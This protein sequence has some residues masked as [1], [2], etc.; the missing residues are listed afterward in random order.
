M[1]ITTELIV[2]LFIIGVL[3]IAASASEQN[4]VQVK[5]HLNRPEEGRIF[6][7]MGYD[8]TF[9]G[10]EFVTL[11]ADRDGIAHLRSFGFQVEIIPPPR[12]F[13]DPIPFGGFKTLSQLTS[14]VDDMIIAHSGIMTDRV[15]IGQSCEGRDIWAVKISDNPDINEDEP[16]LFF[17]S[18]IH[19]NE[20]LTA[21]ALLYTMDYL[22]DNYGSDPEATDII[23]NRELWFVPVTNPDGYYYN[24]LTNPDGGGVWRK[25]RR[26]NGDGTFGVDLNRNF[27]YMWGYNDLG[28]SPITSNDYYRGTG[29]FSEPESQAIRD[30]VLSHEFVISVD[31]HAPGRSYIWP[32][33]YVDMRTPDDNVYTVVMDSMSSYNGFQLSDN[34]TANGVQMDW[35]YGEQSA[36]PQIL[37]M[38]PEVGDGNLW[39]DPLLIEQQ[40]AEHLGPNLFLCRFADSIYYLAPPRIPSIHVPAGP[41]GPDY[42]VSWTHDDTINTAVAFE[43]L[44]YENPA[45]IPDSGNNLDDWTVNWFHITDVDYHSPPTSFRTWV[46]DGNDLQTTEP[47]CI[48]EAET[49]SFWI[50]YELARGYDYV[51]VTVSTDGFSYTAIPGNI[52]T[53]EDPHGY[54][55]GNGITGKSN[56]WVEGIFDLS[57]FA[58][59][60]LWLRFTTIRNANRPFLDPLYLDDILFVKDYQTQTVI[61]DNL[62]DTLYSFVDKT[63]GDYYYR[64]RAKDAQDQWGALSAFGLVTAGEEICFDTDHHGYGDPDHPENTCPVDSY[65]YVLNPDQTDTDSDG[66]GDASDVSYV[67]GDANGDGEVTM[68]DVVYLRDYLHKDGPPPDPMEAGDANGDGSVDQLDCQYLIDYLKK[69][70]PEPVCP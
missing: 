39:T 38:L 26:D 20:P 8:V 54:N 59:A 14:Y 31:Y 41:L 50:N 19:A 29:P 23:D 37:A 27:G 18:L 48:A 2:G 43:L 21:E 69:D 11:V 32:W 49:L 65:P 55:T 58:G 36:K 47:V 24:E 4:P 64:V 68:D 67:C 17:N 6:R 42:I 9:V 25:N 16:E 15:V 44:E 3:T 1:R 56:G 22:T 13:G 51:F 7:G 45:R 53:N 61:A 5:V 30:F 12:L 57:S 35:S 33:G 34:I 70:S 10:D 40:A 62:T 63:A 52:T 60:N 28:S 46:A 66:I